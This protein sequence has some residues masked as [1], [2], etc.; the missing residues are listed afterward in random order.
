MQQTIY[1]CMAL[2]MLL[3]SMIPL[4]VFA[5]GINEPSLFLEK[6]TAGQKDQ[7]L[8]ISITINELKEDAK[9]TASQPAI[10]Q[11]VFEQ[12]GQS[13]NL[14][15]E[16]NQIISVPKNSTGVGIIHL[17]LNE[18]NKLPSIDLNYE[19]QRISFQFDRSE[20][21]SEP[22]AE[23]PNNKESSG[24]ELSS[25]QQ[26]SVS[27]TETSS[28]TYETKNNEKETSEESIK[29]V[30]EADV[31]EK[32]AGPTDIRTYFP[33]GTGTIVTDS[34]LIFLDDKGNVIEPPI[35]PD[36]TVR[37]SYNW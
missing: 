14:T 34:K 13:T 26:S 19:N 2:L 20:E 10:E 11:A 4:K 21:S 5:E 36:S 8:D 22:S 12:N 28:S 30:K 15:V 29:P 27:E 24:S 35:T 31:K 25:E 18:V 7:S 1:G 3:N 33:N 16:N 6:V 32:A 17:I 37:I 9:I 23:N